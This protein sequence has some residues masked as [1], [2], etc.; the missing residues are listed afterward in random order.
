PHTIVQPAFPP[1]RSSDLTIAD[2]EGAIG[3]GDSGVWMPADQQG[4]VIHIDPAT[5]EIIGTV[6]TVPGSVAAAV[7]AGAV[8]VTSTEQ[9]ALRSEEHTSELQ[10]LAYLVC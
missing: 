4:T 5:N 9:S 8:W 7:G 10:S 2:S 6:D 1:R 3:V